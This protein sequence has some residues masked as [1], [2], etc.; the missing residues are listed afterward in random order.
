[1]APPTSKYLVGYAMQGYV[2][3]TS[4]FSQLGQGWTG[5]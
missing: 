2:R 1:M 4:P 3:K 5:R